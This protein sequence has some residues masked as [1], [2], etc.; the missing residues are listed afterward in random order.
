ME[1]K[2]ITP[3]EAIA[4]LNEGEFI[5]TFR[6]PSGLL[7]GCDLNRQSLIDR[8]NSNP[9]NLQI[10]GDAYRQLNHALILEDNGYLFIET[11]AEKLNEF[12]P[13]LDTST[14][15]VSEVQCPEEDKK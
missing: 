15:S 1:K 2:F 14:S 6:N 10:G 4:L 13:L 7:I 5:H 3:E 12:D 8:I 9:K 11:I